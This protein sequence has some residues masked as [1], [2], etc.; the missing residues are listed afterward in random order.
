MAVTLTNVETKV[1]YLVDDPSTS[2]KDL[3][4]YTNTAVFTLT[5]DNVI[6]V[7]TVLIND[8]E[9][10]TSDWSHDTDTN[11]VTISNITWST[12]DSV[13]INYTYYPNFSSTIIQ[14]YVQ[15]ALLHIS[16]ANI[17]DFIVVSSTIYPEPSDREENLIAMI[18]SLLINPDNKGYRLPD[19]TMY[20]PRDLPTHD[21]VRKTLAV[22]KKNT[23]GWLTTL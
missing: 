14:N 5:E 22:F 23:H 10:D 19:V 6:S 3:F 17:K 18:A 7:S 4:S 16:A 21:K 12:G 1:R 2:Q 15:A 8:V 20:V 9:Q 11:K 13:E